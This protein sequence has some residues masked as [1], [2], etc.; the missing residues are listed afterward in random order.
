MSNF[1]PARRA[2]RKARK[3]RRGYAL[4]NDGTANARGEQIEAERRG[5][6]HPSQIRRQLMARLKKST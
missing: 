1:N 5:G 3:D 2:A 6:Y 4:R